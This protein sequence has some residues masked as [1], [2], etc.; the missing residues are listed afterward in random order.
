MLYPQCFNGAVC[1]NGLIASLTYSVVS[2]IICG[3]IIIGS[4]AGSIGRRNG[5]ITT[6]TFMTIGSLGMTF[7]AFVFQKSPK[8]MLKNLVLFLFIFGFG[9]GGECQEC[10]STSKLFLSYLKKVKDE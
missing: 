3:M 1:S 7:G 9:V 10:S 6:A 5:S 2:G 8:A 4:V